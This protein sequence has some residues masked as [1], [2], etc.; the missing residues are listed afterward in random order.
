MSSTGRWSYHIEKN[1]SGSG[2]SPAWFLVWPACS[3]GIYCTDEQDARKQFAEEKGQ[4]R[5][6]KYEAVSKG[7]GSKSR[8]IG[9][10][11]QPITL[12]EK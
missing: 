9:I 6:V 7:G 4:M 2:T 10:T 1:L 12:E 8:T 3:F 5:L 11:G